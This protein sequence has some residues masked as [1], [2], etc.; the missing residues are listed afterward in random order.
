MSDEGNKKWVFFGIGAA[1]IAT[2]AYLI[3]RTKREETEE[4]VMVERVNF[5]DPSLS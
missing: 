5:I 1:A 3:F 4:D 2:A